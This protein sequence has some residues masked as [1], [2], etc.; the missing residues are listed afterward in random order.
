M[1]VL[2]QFYDLNGKGILLENIDNMIR[3]KIG[4][5]LDNSTYSIE[6]DI[7]TNYVISHNNLQEI[8]QTLEKDIQHQHTTMLDITNYFI[9]K[10]ISFE[11]K[12]FR[13]DRL[14][15]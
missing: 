9:E 2:F 15:S 7:F 3:L 4:L 1:P 13:S 14:N 12:R 10:G 8:R 11:K 5:P 6:Y